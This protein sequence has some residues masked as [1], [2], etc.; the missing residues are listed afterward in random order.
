MEPWMKVVV[1]LPVAYGAV[2]LIAVLIL[3]RNLNPRIGG[4]MSDGIPLNPGSGGKTLETTELAN[5]RQVQT[6]QVVTIV[7]GEGGAEAHAISEDNPLPIT[8]I[9]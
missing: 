1:L 6:L 3:N 2:A 5:G 8:I 9:E 7:E 4:T